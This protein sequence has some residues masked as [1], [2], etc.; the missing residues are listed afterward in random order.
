MNKI[1]YGFS[2]ERFNAQIV[3]VVKHKFT[4]EYV[5]VFSSA[6]VAHNFL[7]NIIHFQKDELF[8]QAAIVDYYAR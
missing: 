7:H 4:R 6:E 3:Y 1:S 5:A 8:I 2:G